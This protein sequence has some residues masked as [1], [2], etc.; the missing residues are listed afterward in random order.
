LEGNLFT[1][2]DSEYSPFDRSRIEVPDWTGVEMK[3]E[4]M[5]MT[6]D[7]KSIQY[8]VVQEIHKSQGP[9]ILFDDD[10][11]KDIADIVAI[12]KKSRAGTIIRICLH[13]QASSA[14]PGHAFLHPGKSA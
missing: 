9:D 8:R 12:V 1:S 4:S 7:S 2:L 5:G 6:K 10:Y 13:G 14:L 3:I 11:S